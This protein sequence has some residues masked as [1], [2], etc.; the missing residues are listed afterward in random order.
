M[1]L[2][3][4][5]GGMFLVLFLGVGARQGGL[6][7]GDRTRILNRGIFYGPLPALV[8]VSTYSEPL[9]RLV[10][11]ALIGGLW[12]VLGLTVGLA[13]LVHRRADP[14]PSRAVA[15]VQSYHSNFGYVGLPLVAATLGDTAAGAASL[16]LGIGAL[17]QIPLTSLLL[18][19]IGGADASLQAELRSVA[20]NPV[21]LALVVGLAFS[22]ADWS[23]PGAAAT[24]LGW[25]STLALPLALLC[26][27]SSLELPVPRSELDTVGSV[28]GLKV[29]CMPALAWLVFSLLGAAPLT[30]QAGV[31]MFGAP[32]AVSTF[33]YAGELGGDT[34]LASVNIFVTTAV[35]LVTMLGAAR[36]LL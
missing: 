18:I 25:L 17:T 31:L 33:V 26:V 32:S 9:A 29:L 4:R 3:V 34:S 6:L 14:E 20:T 1:S 12:L 30:L 35:S 36:L 10:S 16:I 22:S 21:V 11:P 5:L 8:F 23:I 15:I 27:G 19:R 28:V 24:G 2:V 7:T 13:W